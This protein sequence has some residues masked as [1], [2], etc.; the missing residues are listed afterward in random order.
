MDKAANM[1]RL[2][3]YI[4]KGRV[5]IFSKSTCPYCDMAKDLF[6]NLGVKYSSVEV[7]KSKEFPITFVNF[8]NDHAKI[9]TYPKI[10]IGEECI[11]GYTDTDKLFKNMKLFDKLKKE[12]I[13]YDDI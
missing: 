10:Y 4:S 8:L 3:N 6:S 7:D 11:G 1:V 13:H 9:K 12:G 5:F 2:Y